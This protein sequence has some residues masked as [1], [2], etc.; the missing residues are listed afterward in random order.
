MEIQHNHS[1]YTLQGIQPMISISTESILT[2]CI[3]S[4]HEFGSVLTFYLMRIS[5]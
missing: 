4:R 3:L 1:V 5:R 2:S